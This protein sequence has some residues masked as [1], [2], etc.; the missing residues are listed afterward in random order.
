MPKPGDDAS[1]AVSNGASTATGDD[2]STAKR[3]DAQ[4]DAGARRVELRAVIDRTEGDIAV[5]SLDNAKTTALD[6]PLSRLPAG[7][8]DGDHLRLTF[9]GEPAEHTLTHAT[10]DRDARSAAA[11]RIKQMQERLE[12]LSGTAGKKDFKL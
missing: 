5:L 9:A 2:A 3:D 4:S 12:R 6:V 1:K 8:T 7:A 10:I 11:D